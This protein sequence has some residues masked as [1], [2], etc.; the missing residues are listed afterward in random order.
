MTALNYVRDLS[1]TVVAAAHGHRALAPHGFW[2]CCVVPLVFRAPPGPAAACARGRRPA[3]EPSA[4][5]ASLGASAR[6]PARPCHR[7][8][9]PRQA[10]PTPSTPVTPGLLIGLAPCFEA[11]VGTATA[12]RHGSL[13][14]H[15]FWFCLMIPRIFHTPPAP[16]K[17]AT[18]GV[19]AYGLARIPT[20]AS[21][22]TR[23]HGLACY[24]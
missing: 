15:G 14:P 12:H 23:V 1:E 18:P 6:C 5:R 10:P 20:A 22:R 9:A 19:R 8:P 3:R 7:P 21:N 11:Q 16:S 24:R 13:T 2:Y 17:P 4:P